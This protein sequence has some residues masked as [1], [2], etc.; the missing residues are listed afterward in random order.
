MTPA[1][2]E[3]LKF[4]CE[5]YWWPL[6]GYIRRRGY[7]LEEAEDLTQAFFA[8]LLEETATFRR[9]DP[10]RGKFRT[11]LLG[12]LRHFLSDQSDKGRA[13]KRGGGQKVIR[14]DIDAA[15][16]RLG[17]AVTNHTRSP[18]WYF[19]REWGLTVLR[20]CLAELHAEYLREG[21]GVLFEKLQ[22][23]LSGDLPHADH[24]NLARELGTTEGA[25]KVALHRLRRRYGDCIRREI[26]RTLGSAAEV[27]EEVKHLFEILRS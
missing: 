12:A 9:A 17:T 24:R 20:V 22:R 2:R 25:L 11:Y 4:L 16:G 14:L 27:D 3:A 5:T 23:S 6:Y 21:K 15:E 26:A 1:T 18:E 7:R 19:D 13:V 8:K 10:G